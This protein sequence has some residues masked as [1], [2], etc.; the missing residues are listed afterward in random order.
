M[1]WTPK[2]RA[3]GRALRQARQDRGLTLREFALQIG[4]DAGVLSR[5]ETGERA[6]KP[7]RVAQILAVLGLSG[8]RYDEIM[9]LAYGISEP[10]WVA[11]TLPEQRQQMEAFLDSESRATQIVEVAP[12]LIPG[13]L[14]TADY[15]RAI[16][17]GGGVP[18]GEIAARVATRLGRRE[19]INR[20]QKPAKFLAL[21]GQSAFHWDVGGRR[22]AIE[23]LK[24]VADVA[25]RSNVEIRVVPYGVGWGPLLEGAFS[26]IEPNQSAPVVFV[27]TRRSS[28]CLHLDE[29][30][31]AYR[32]AVDTILKV[33]LSP[34]DSRN[35]IA[36]ICKRMEK[37]DGRMAQVQ[38]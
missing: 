36:E 27:E 13:L 31:N 29:D 4:R 35:F 8:E 34:Q 24:H 22:A 30:V 28:L 5:W 21:I 2:A 25:G 1:A 10:Q 23:Q 12:L 32:E 11:T 37:Q 19:V 15:V 6:P 17:T 7:E 33:A 9:T 20:S 3:L 14:Q 16:M 26:L 38:S 18:Q